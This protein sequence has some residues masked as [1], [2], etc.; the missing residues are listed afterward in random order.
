MILYLLLPTVFSECMI[1]KEHNPA[2]YCDDIVTWPVSAKVESEAFERSQSAFKLY[3]NLKTKYLSEEDPKPTLECLAVAREFYCA[4]SY[5]YCTDSEE[6]RG[7]CE[8]LCDIWKDRCPDEYDDKNFILCNNSESKNCSYG[9][10]AVYSSLLI[11]LMIL[12]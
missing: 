11:A 4:Y 2:F 8:F 9:N 3:Y 6:E 12:T 7:V 10:W 1:Y 5:P